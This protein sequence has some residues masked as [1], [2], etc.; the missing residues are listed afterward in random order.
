MNVLFT[1]RG[2]AAL[3]AVGVTATPLG[4]M[5]QN[6]VWQGNVS[7]TGMDETTE[8][9]LSLVHEFTMQLRYIPIRFQFGF[10]MAVDAYLLNSMSGEMC[11]SFRGKLLFIFLLF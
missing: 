10:M 2:L 5:W 3:N 11:S 4:E 6:V 7:T 1:E 9:S 8:T